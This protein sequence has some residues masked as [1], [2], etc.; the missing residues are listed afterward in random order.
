MKISI[1]KKTV[2]WSLFLYAAAATAYS[3]MTWG[4]MSE[5]NAGLFGDSFG[6]F[7]GIVSG[8]AFLGVLGALLLQIQ[9]LAQQQKQLELQ[10]EEI[11]LQREDLELNRK[12]LVRSA[13]AQ[14]ESQQALSQQVR[15]MAI[16]SRITLCHELYPI[17]DNLRVASLSRNPQDMEGHARYTQ[18]AKR[19]RTELEQIFEQTVVKGDNTPNQ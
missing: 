7:N 19:C 8:L 15:H 14:E 18:L 17:F 13:V 1:T 10:Q 5:G 12:E 9:A 2:I 3:L 16:A 11:R 6:A 4:W